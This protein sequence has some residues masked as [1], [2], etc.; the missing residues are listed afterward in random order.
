MD[1]SKAHKPAY[2]AFS[3]REKT[4]LCVIAALLAAVIAITCISIN[5]RMN[6]Q[7]EYAAVRTR[8]EESLYANLNMLIQTFDMTSVP[9]AD[10]KNSVIPQMKN[11]FIASITLNDLIGETFGSRYKALSDSDISAIRTAFSSYD[12]AFRS[13][14]PT[15]LAQ[16]D[17]QSCITR[18][19][20]LLNARFSD[21]RLKYS[22]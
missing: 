3:P 17:M 15:D 6:I 13:D 20:S 21:S 11:Y 8:M 7:N 10:V 19:R 22:R 5:M 1:K 4:L 12:A 18:T 2:T 14:A 16:A 9:N